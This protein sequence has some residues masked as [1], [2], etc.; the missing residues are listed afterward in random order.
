MSYESQAASMSTIE[1]ASLMKSHDEQ[2]ISITEQKQSITE[3]IQRVAWFER[4]LF[5]TKS[6]RRIFDVN[7]DQLTLGEVRQGGDTESETVNV[8]GHRRR[9][10]PDKSE[11]DD[12]LLRFDPSVPVQEITIENKAIKDPENTQ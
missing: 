4:Q 11:T 2:K 3:L 7:G 1:I 10:S 8:G 12:Q 5:G 9:R 6:E